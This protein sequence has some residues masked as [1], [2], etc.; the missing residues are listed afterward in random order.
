MVSKHLNIK[1]NCSESPK[2]RIPFSGSGGWEKGS[3]RNSQEGNTE[4]WVMVATAAFKPPSEQRQRREL[5]AQGRLW[6]GVPRHRWQVLPRTWLAGGLCLWLKLPPGPAGI[7]HAPQS[8]VGEAAK[9]TS[10]AGWS[11][12]N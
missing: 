8:G 3:G 7:V 1:R 11:L 9:P 5:L 2:L 4:Y 12:C 10:P 6:V